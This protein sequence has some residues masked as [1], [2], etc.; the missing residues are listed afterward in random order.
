[1]R[2]STFALVA[3]LACPLQAAHAEEAGGAGIVV[4]FADKSSLPL[5]SWSLS[6]EYEASREGSLPTTARR[7][8]RDLLVGKKDLPTAGGV[9]EISYREYERMSGG[10]EPQKETVGVVTGLV[11]IAGGKKSSLRVE[12]PHR[13]LLVPP[14]SGKGLT[15][16][17]RGLD[18][19]GM[20][21][22]GAKRSFCLL[23][24]AP[25]VECSPPASDRIVK[26]EF[27]R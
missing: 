22:T 15:I 12:A 2:D 13:D 26:I 23:A 19:T 17:A 9:L 5:T 27:E 18:L 24:Y 7:E 4:T 8:S 11:F 6:Y 21:L 25:Q 1:M 14:A 20:T 3:L 10:D 16:Q